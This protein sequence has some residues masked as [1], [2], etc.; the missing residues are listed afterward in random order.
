VVI[1]LPR[2]EFDDDLIV[3]GFPARLEIANFFQRS[4]RCIS[5][6]PNPR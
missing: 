4:L 5:S 3:F 2:I 6:L 1:A